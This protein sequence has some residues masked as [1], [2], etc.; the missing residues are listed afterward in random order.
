MNRVSKLPGRECLYYR[1]GCCL[2]E[3]YRNPMLNRDWRCLVLKQWEKAHD[4]FIDRAERF[5]LDEEDAG[6]LWERI[7]LPM[8]KDYSRCRMYTPGVSDEAIDCTSFLG[9]LCLKL[10]PPCKGVC[11]NFEPMIVADESER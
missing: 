3:E 2:R 9:G 10:L 4:D 11:R 6:K 5:Q 7:F 8:Q 1:N